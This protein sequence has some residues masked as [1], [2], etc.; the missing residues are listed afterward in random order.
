M[1]GPF[2][3]CTMLTSFKM[4]RILVVTTALLSPSHDGSFL[5]P[6]GKGDFLLL[7]DVV[8]SHG[9]SHFVSLWALNYMHAY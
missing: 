3:R 8:R 5:V 4:V 6:N 2:V 7:F 1:L 9:V